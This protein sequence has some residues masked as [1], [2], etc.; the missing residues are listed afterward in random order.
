MINGY[1]V[2]N[3]DWT[4]RGFQY[5]VG[6]IYEHEGEISPC[7]SG[8]HFCKKAAD[9]FGYYDFDSNNKVAEV[10]ALGDIKTDGDKSVTNKI[11]I[12][13]EL[14]WNEVLEIVNIGKDNTGLKNIGDWNS[15]NFNRGSCNSGDCNSGGFNSGDYNSG[16]FCTITPKPMI[17]NK[18]T[19]YTRSAICHMPGMYAIR[20]YFNLNKWIVLSDMTDQEKADHPECETFGG[21][22]KTYGYKEAWKNTW[23]EMTE[24][25]RESVKA[26]PNFD[27]DI[28]YDI[29]GIIV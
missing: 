23:D 8:F 7:K 18:A 27:P 14:S 6:K 17:F 11:K 3:S 26:L 1:K 21:Y 16:F 22:L 29:T 20:K 4:C 13:R 12:V 9:C 10:E 5:E 19:E 28:F 25:D 15:G 24:S 2:F